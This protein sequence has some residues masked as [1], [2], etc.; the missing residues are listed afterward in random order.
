MYNIT[1]TCTIG[2]YIINS[3]KYQILPPR[4]IDYMN[5][6]NVNTTV[7]SG[8]TGITQVIGRVCRWH[9][10]RHVL[11]RSLHNRKVP[12]NQFIPRTKHLIP[13]NL[14]TLIKGRVIATIYDRR[15]I[16][17][18]NGPYYMNSHLLSF[19][20]NVSYRWSKILLYYNI[21]KKIQF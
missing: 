13:A 21:F 5:D 20:S 1:N 9:Q 14:G 3:Y 15:Y 2:R 19:H 18:T 11:C 10:S 4:M 6:W 16:S 8:M 7:D 12:E 17:E